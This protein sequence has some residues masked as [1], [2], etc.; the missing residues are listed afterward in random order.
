MYTDYEANYRRAL[1]ALME[2]ERVDFRAHCV[3]D[4]KG[5]YALVADIPSQD[6]YCLYLGPSIQA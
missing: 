3:D 4:G 6:L 5:L 1:I 2:D